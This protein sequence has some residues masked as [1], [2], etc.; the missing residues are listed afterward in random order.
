MAENPPAFP[1][2]EQVFSDGEMNVTR[3][4]SY[5]MT[6]RDYFAGQAIVGLIHHYHSERGIGPN[7]FAELARISYVYADAMLVAREKDGA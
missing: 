5:G 2:P 3:Q 7:P 4:G 6:L 1:I